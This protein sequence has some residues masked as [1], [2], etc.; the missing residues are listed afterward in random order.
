MLLLLVVL[1]P[2]VTSGQ[3]YGPPPDK[4][5]TDAMMKISDIS[6]S[7]LNNVLDEPDS[8][9]YVITLLYHY[10]DYDGK[11][12]TMTVP[13]NDYVFYVFQIYSKDMIEYPKVDRY[14]KHPGPTW[15]PGSAPVGYSQPVPS[16]V[17][18]LKKPSKQ[19]WITWIAFNKKNPT[20]MVKKGNFLIRPKGTG[21]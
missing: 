12:K 16:L 1:V 13:L 20:G 8:M 9:L 4:T 6:Y 21:R 5:N 19:M 14:I 15:E 7:V 17:G 11:Y 3:I 10:K 18:M 2:L